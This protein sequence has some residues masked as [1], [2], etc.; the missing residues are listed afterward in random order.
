MKE[1]RKQRNLQGEKEYFEAG[2]T[3]EQI[4]E[5]TMRWEAIMEDSAK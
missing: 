3:S 5:I 2:F 4:R 1:V